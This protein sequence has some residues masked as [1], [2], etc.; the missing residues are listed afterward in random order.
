VSEHDPIAA[1]S[2][3]CPWFPGEEDN[4][5]HSADVAALAALKPYGRV[6]GVEQRQEN[7]SPFVVVRYGALTFRVAPTLCRPVAPPPFTIGQTVVTPKGEEAVVREVMWHH[8]R[9]APYFLLSIAGKPKAKRY[10][11]AELKSR[12]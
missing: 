2:V 4:R 11:P 3:L 8:L 5:V 1:G 6:F 7:Q 10:W 12:A 9:Q